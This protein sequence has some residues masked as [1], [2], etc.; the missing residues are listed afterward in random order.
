MFLWTETLH[1]QI[2]SREWCDLL[3]QLW[4]EGECPVPTSLKQ[5]P[6]PGRLCKFPCPKSGTPWICTVSL[7]DFCSKHWSSEKS[8]CWCFFLP[9][10]DLAASR[11]VLRYPFW[12]LP[13][14]SRA[15]NCVLC[16][17]WRPPA[18]S[19]TSSKR[20]QMN[21]GLQIF[22]KHAQMVFQ[23][24]VTSYRWSISAT[25]EWKVRRLRFLVK[26]LRNQAISNIW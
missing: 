4:L 8:V 19:H 26:W 7:L 24:P 23:A 1:T 11:K 15:H 10:S 12:S 9:P 21:S 20:V 5:C 22:G 16:A 6:S 3:G 17:V 14:N 18:P 2:Q 25:I 13:K